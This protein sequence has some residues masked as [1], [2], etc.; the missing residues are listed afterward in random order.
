[1]NTTT[2]SYAL[3][4]GASKGLGKSFAKELAKNHHNVLL[5][6]SANEG[7]E[8]LSR[9]IQY[10]YGVKADYFETDLTDLNQIDKLVSW[11]KKNY[12]VDVLINNAGLGS[13]CEFEKSSL[14][15]LDKIVK[16]NMR[17]ITILTHQFLPILKKNEQ[18]FILNVSSMASFSPVGYKSIYP[19]SKQFVQSFSIGLNEELK[20]TCVS[21]SVVHPGSMNTN[22]F[23]K[24]RIAKHGLLIRAGVVSTDIVAA[25][26]LKGM[27]HHKKVIIVGWANYLMRFLMFL[28]PGFIRLPLM[29]NAVRKE[30]EL[31]MIKNEAS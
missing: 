18:A 16:L 2:N 5:V 13:S 9:S 10:K 8:Q 1:M 17:A 6:A 30:V 14:D 28:I 22:K 11:V 24:D 31:T 23:V 4:T 29:T 27:F 19:A 25:T 3:V 26:A 15:F 21:V 20:H 7:L 12:A